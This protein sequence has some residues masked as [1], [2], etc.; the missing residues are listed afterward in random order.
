MSVVQVFVG[1]HMAVVAH[2]VE[3]ETI[4]R[5]TKLQL[6]DE[7]G[8]LSKFKLR[9]TLIICSISV[10]IMPTTLRFSRNFWRSES[11]WKGL[12]HFLWKPLIRKI[13]DQF[14]CQPRIELGFYAG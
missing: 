4:G 1:A 11:N 6:D 10:F 2:L 13:P 7:V 14:D 8:M 12:K 5:I 9:V 3:S